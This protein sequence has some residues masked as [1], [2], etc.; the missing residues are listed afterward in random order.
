MEAETMPVPAKRGRPA[1]N[2]PVYSDGNTLILTEVEHARL[3]ELNRELDNLLSGIEKNLRYTAQKMF[4]IGEIIE[5]MRD[6]DVTLKLKTC[7]ALVGIEYNRASIAQR[8][9]KQFKY[10]PNQLEGMTMSKLL[11]LIRVKRLPDGTDGGAEARQIQYASFPAGGEEAARESFGIAPLSG[12]SLLRYRIRAE[13]QDGKYYLL[14]K[15]CGAAIPIASLSVDTPRN[16]EQQ[17]A[18]REMQ[19]EIQC[20]MERYYAVIEQDEEDD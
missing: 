8:T 6:R 15:G 10:A 17:A 19:D 3:N 13:P 2:A 4:E 9:Y 14:E 7:A 5:L 1:K 20:A 12:A 16:A 11:P 18:F